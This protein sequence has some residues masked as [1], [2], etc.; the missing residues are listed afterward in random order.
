MIQA[1]VTFPV[2]LLSLYGMGEWIRAQFLGKEELSIS[3]VGRALGFGIFAHAVLMTAL[4]FTF[5]LTKPVAGWVTFL[6]AVIFSPLWI[7]FII[8]IF[9]KKP[10]SDDRIPWSLSE[11]VMILVLIL[12]LG[13]R[14]FNALA[15]NISWDATSHHYLIAAEWLN[16]GGV[17]DVPSVIFSYY[18][19]ITEIGIAGTMAF[20]TD[21]LSNLYGWV[22]GLV[23]T[24]L[25]I[26]IPVR[27]YSD[28]PIFKQSFTGRLQGLHRGRIAGLFAAFFFMIFPGNGVQMSGGYVDLP[29]AMW[30]LLSIDMIF[31]LMYTR[32]MSTG[33]AAAIFAGA[34]MA[35]KHLGILLFAGLLVMLLWVILVELRTEKVK[36]NKFAMILVFIIMAILVPAPWYIRAIDLTGNPFYPFGVFGLPAPPQP[37]FTPSSWI[38]P[39]YHRSIIGFLNY[40]MYLV[41]TPEVGD[42]LGRN[43]PMISFLTFPLIYFIPRLKSG[44]RMMAILSIISIPIIYVLFPV[45][46]RYHIPF[47]A[48]L[49][50]TFG[51]LITHIHDYPYNKYFSA[52]FIFLA[53]IPSASRVIGDPTI[54]NLDYFQTT[55]TVTSIALIGFLLLL[56]IW[57]RR[58]AIPMFLLLCVI[59]S[60]SIDMKYDIEEYSKRKAVILNKEP[61]DSYLLRESAYNYRAI[62]YINNVMAWHDMKILCLEPRTYRLKAQWVT[63]FGLKEPVVPTTP[64]ENVAIWYRGGFTHILLGDDVG[65]KALIYYNIVHQ[66]GWD[67][68]GASHG[69][70]VE[71]LQ[72]HPEDNTVK[73]RLHDLWK[74]FM[75]EDF[76]NRGRHF[77]RYW[78]P[79][80]L[81]K[82]GYPTEMIN[83]EIWYTAR[84][85]DILN[86]PEK[87]AQYAFVRDFREMV[88]TGGL[89][90][91]YTDMLTFLFECDYP[92][93]RRS[94]PDVDLENLGLLE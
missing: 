5:I 21:Y 62:H 63:W 77:T 55:I 36:F 51:L 67:V 11:I 79:R 6:P 33:I 28:E 3:R 61:E 45:E 22:F 72:E 80:E 1:V 2:L 43:Y 66:N 13:L 59:F 85:M 48:P 27:H 89:K 56:P 40:W 16:S 30:A 12:I 17:R 7:T 86:T 75:G 46:T 91:V 88:D 82:E 19:S 26:G 18:P 29:L 65:L 69:E 25:L 94:H 84:R 71:Y 60:F 64:E 54:S 81:E 90:V 41:A 47:L 24:L 31:E 20:G 74:N 52:F 35:T 15:P 8:E 78:I 23:A 10:R 76:G 68:P 9:K 58:T 50:L 38:R 4:G 44:M 53:L 83:G 70:M 39:D 37:P 73:F 14:L 57:I 87:V 92:A 32:R 49:A 93:Y 34:C 42:A